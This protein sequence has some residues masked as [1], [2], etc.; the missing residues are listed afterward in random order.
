MDEEQPLPDAGVQALDAF[1]ERVDDVL[2]VRPQLAALV[3]AGVVGRFQD[4]SNGFAL[5]RAD[6]VGHSVDESG[7]R[8]LHGLAAADLQ[9]V[10]DHRAGGVEALV[11]M[12]G[13]CGVATVDH[14]V[15]LGGRALDGPGQDVPLTRTEPVGAR[16]SAA[17]LR[18][19]RVL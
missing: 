19:G 5:V 11:V 17:R 14:E 3:E 9:G 15:G 2:V 18:D 10:G 16:G 8:V 7:D 12:P 1:L 13:R 6:L 4:H